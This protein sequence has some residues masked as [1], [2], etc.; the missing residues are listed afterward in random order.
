M[1]RICD[2]FFLRKNN[3]TK[4]N[5]VTSTTKLPL[6]L[7]LFHTSTFCKSLG[8]L[9]TRCLNNNETLRMYIKP[10]APAHLHYRKTANEIRLPDLIVVVVVVVV[11]VVA[12]VVIPLHSYT[13]N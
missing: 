1:V 10:L 5:H 12:V 9:F 2:A 7:F 3:R 4:N 11:F 13:R 8:I 6:L